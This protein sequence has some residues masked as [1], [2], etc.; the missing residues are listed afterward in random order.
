M[1]VLVQNNNN[2]NF[3]SKIKFV[4]SKDFD[5]RLFNHIIFC[6]PSTAPIENSFKKAESLRTYEVR[7]CTAGGI[8]DKDGVLGFHIYDC[9]D[10]VQKIVEN[11]SGVIKKLN[12]ESLSALVLG[13]KDMPNSRHSVPLCEAVTGIVGKILNPS[14]FKAHTNKFAQTDLGY[15]KMTDTWYIDTTIPENP[16]MPYAKRKSVTTLKELLGSFEK[17]TIA[18]QDRLFIG[19]KEITKD[20]CPDIF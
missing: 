12:K 16:M 19:G 4:S 2:I 3:Q 8:V 5:S 11:L 13:A 18:P 7:T 20:I 10:N 17:I 14:V 6:K 15:S 1:N 9:R